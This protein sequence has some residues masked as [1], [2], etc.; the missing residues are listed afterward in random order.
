MWVPTVSDQNPV[1]CC[2]NFCKYLSI[3]YTAICYSKHSDPPLSILGDALASFLERPDV[4]PRH[5][6]CI[7]QGFSSRLQRCVET[8]S[9]QGMAPFKT[10]L[11]LD[12]KPAKMVLSPGDVSGNVDEAAIYTEQARQ[13][14]S[15]LFGSRHLTTLRYP[16]FRFSGA[17]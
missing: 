6:Y 15:D 16:G 7:V 9:A 14:R 17:L 10:A 2:G 1:V 12:P 8:A 5:E 13:R 11:G 3:I 4:H